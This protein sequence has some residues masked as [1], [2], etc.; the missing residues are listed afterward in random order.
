[1]S[2]IGITHPQARSS[3]ITL[4]HTEPLSWDYNDKRHMKTLGNQSTTM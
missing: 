4:I 1:M 2:K 3:N